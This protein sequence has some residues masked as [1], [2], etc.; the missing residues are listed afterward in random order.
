[1]R[2]VGLGP[3]LRVSEAALKVALSGVLDLFPGSRD[4][5]QNLGPVVV[6]LGSCF[7]AGSQPGP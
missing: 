6:G 2:P 3:L 1:M 7:F 4:C 5:W